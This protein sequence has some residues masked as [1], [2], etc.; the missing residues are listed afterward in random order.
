MKAVG[1]GG[2]LDVA[3]ARLG[4]ALVAVGIACLCSYELR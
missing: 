2:G 3:M 4:M 1:A